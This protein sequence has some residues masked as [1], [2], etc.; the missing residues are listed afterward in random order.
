MIMV[1]GRILSYLL[2][3]VTV[4]VY[5]SA[6]NGMDISAIETHVNWRHLDRTSCGRT[7]YDDSKER[8][9]DGDEAKIGQFPWLAR[10]GVQMETVTL[11]SCAGSLLNRYYVLSAAHCGESHNVV[12]LGEHDIIT[13]EDC[14]D[15][16]CVPPVQDINIEQHY[17][18]GYNTSSHLRDFQII[19]LQRPAIYNDFVKPVCLPYGHVLTKNFIGEAVKIAGWGYTD[20]KTLDLPEVLMYIVAPVLHRSTCNAVYKHPLDETQ[21]CIGFKHERKDSCSGDSG[22]PVT[23][24]MK[25][26]EKRQHFQIAIVSYG[27]T[28]CGNGPAVYTNVLYYMPLILDQI[29]KS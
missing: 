10:I 17:F 1:I 18:F 28:V 21:F 5:A 2:C 22:A 12:R 20:T 8:I 16:V 15:D 25:A 3:T 27:L 11:F 14:E 13:K 19:L 23:K 9:I 29:V 4:T 7:R 24:Y 26:S 6:S